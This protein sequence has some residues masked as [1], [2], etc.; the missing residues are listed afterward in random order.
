MFIN[1]IADQADVF[2]DGISS[3][4]EARVVIAEQLSLR[5]PDLHEPDRTRAIQS[6]LDSLDREGFL[7]LRGG[8][9]DGDEAGDDGGGD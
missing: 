4:D 1:E 6:V 5:H 8:R 9:K 2:L 3:R 7:D